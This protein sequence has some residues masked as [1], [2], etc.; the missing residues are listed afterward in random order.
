M[1]P[2]AFGYHRPKSVQEALGVL[3]SNSEAKLLAGGHSLIPLM[4]MRFAQPQHLID[5]RGLTELKG[6]RVEGGHLAIGSMTTHW[7]VQS[8]PLVREKCPVL[9]EVA[10]GIGD[11]Q[12][13][14][15]GTIGGSLVHAD[16]GAD[17][18]AI[19]L[20]MDAELVCQGSAGRRTVKASGWFHSLMT[21][22]IREDEILVD[23]RFP[24]PAA[25]WGAAYL[26]LPDPASRLAMLGVAA[27]VGLDATDACL[28]AGLGV[29]GA[30]SVP[31]RGISAERVLTGKKLDD[32]LIENAAN[33]IVDDLE[34]EAH[35]TCTA[36]DRRELCKVL[37]RRAVTLAKD[38]A[39]AGFLAGR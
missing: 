2:A 16:P 7:E 1:Y 9:S 25:P 4:K 21:T 3:Q 39:R 29:T 19:T 18:P 5:L 27:V 11:P 20:A 30:S 31:G 8:S 28:W 13:R 12:V 6:V 17:Y 33:V 15:C 26:K 24:L 34:F 10:A 37:T 38:R 35:R 32:E 22:E 23:I 36:E 14:N